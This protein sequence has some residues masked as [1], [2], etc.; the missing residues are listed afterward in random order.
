MLRNRQNPNKDPIKRMESNT[1]R[2]VAKLTLE[3]IIKN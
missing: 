2:I 1:D 3:D